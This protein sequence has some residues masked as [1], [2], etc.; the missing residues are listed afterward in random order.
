VICGSSDV[1]IR[2][3]GRKDDGRG[4]IIISSLRPSITFVRHCLES[5]PK[6]IFFC[7]R[8]RLTVTVCF[9]CP[10]SRNEYP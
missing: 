4:H 6:I 2:K 9:N 8:V 10:L 3:D 7:L 1:C 5:S